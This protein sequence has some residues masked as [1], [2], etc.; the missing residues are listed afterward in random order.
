MRL[1]RG[2]GAGR[3]AGA[4][5]AHGDLEP[6]PVSRVRLLPAAHT[7]DGRGCFLTGFVVVFSQAVVEGR[8]RSGFLAPAGRGAP[9]KPRSPRWVTVRAVTPSRGQG[10]LLQRAPPGGRRSASRAPVSVTH[11]GTG[12]LKR[13]HPSFRPAE[14]QN[15]RP[16]LAQGL[17]EKGRSDRQRPGP[18]SGLSRWVRTA[19]PHAGRAC[20]SSQRILLLLR[21]LFS[22]SPSI[23][24]ASGFPVA[25]KHE[26]SGLHT[27]QLSGPPLH[28]AR[29]DTDRSR[30]KT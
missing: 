16:Q 22:P 4:R 13:V 24:L 9:Q 29:N 5:G 11:S 28:H 18:C 20:S 25:F 19:G 6:P 2:A 1:Q 26:S 10:R 23:S 7:G 27:I 17:A 8:P 3:G 14:L 30:V 15:H 12:S 21:F